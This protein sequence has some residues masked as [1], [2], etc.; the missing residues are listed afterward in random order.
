ME[1]QVISNQKI[2]DLQDQ[3]NRITIFLSKFIFSDR[4][5]ILKK[6]GFVDSYTSD[7]DIMSILELS[8]NQRFLFLLFKTSKMKL[9]ELKKIT[10][11]LS[12]VPVNIV[13][14][15][16]LVNDYCMIV[17]D[18]PKNFIKD[19]DNVVNGRY[20]KLSEE[21][22]KHFPTSRDVKNSKGQRIGAEYTLYY[23]IFNKT[24]WLKSFWME[25]LGLI[26]LDDSMELW[27]GPSESDLVFNKEKILK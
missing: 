6:S 26:E 11:E 17:L 9:E 5:D 15:Y 12:S 4:F 3:Y 21:F 8:E 10:L 13:F 18:F 22:T 1:K 14:T 25:R 23:H 2:T 24:N 27:E 16:E 19:Y 7:P 20:S